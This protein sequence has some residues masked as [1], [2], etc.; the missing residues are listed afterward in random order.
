MLS[1][2]LILIPLGSGFNIIYPIQPG[3]L[4]PHTPEYQENLSSLK[5]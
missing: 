1:L 5:N 2:F 4:F 3:N